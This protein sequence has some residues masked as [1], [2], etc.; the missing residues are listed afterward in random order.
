MDSSHPVGDFDL[1]R[2]ICTEDGKI[3][4]HEQRQ[5]IGLLLAA[6]DRRQA[7]DAVLGHDATI[8]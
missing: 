8:A 1:P 5:L 3:F 4:P 7:R 6:A 2:D